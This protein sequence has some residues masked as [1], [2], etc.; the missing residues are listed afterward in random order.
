M[1]KIALEIDDRPLELD[2]LVAQGTLRTTGSILIDFEIAESLSHKGLE[3]AHNLNDK[4]AEA[5]ILWNLLNIYRRTNRENEAITVGKLSYELAEA[6]NLKEQMAYSAIDMVKIYVFMGQGA[7]LM[8]YGWRAVELWR[9]L[10]NRPML[11]DALTTQA[12][13]LLGIGQ[14]DQALALSA[15]AKIISQESKNLWGEALSYYAPA[16]VHTEQLNI[17][18]ALASFNSGLGLAEEGGVTIIQ[19]YMNMFQTNLYLAISDYQ[20]AKKCSERMMSIAEKQLPFHTRRA[21]G[22][23]ALVHLEMGDMETAAE[24]INK[25]GYDID[26]FELNYFLMVEKAVGQYLLQKEAYSDLFRLTTKVLESLEENSLVALMSDFHYLQAQ[27]LFG[28]QKSDEA[29]ITL[30]KGLKISREFEGRRGILKLTELLAEL[31]G[32]AGNET[33]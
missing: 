11:V 5:K 21:I 7:K 15:E 33:A 14:F 1:E 19:F 31:E 16:M 10:D 32:K 28:L 2:A 4:A 30:H 29:K 27:A 6:L 25:L 24:L 3:L 20:S 13:V 18:A 12:F 17:E 26:N 23:L 8:S 22:T 9:E